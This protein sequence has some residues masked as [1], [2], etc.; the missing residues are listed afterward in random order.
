MLSIIS[1]LVKAGAYYT[2][3]QVTLLEWRL[4]DAGKKYFT[5]DENKEF[6]KKLK[7]GDMRVVDA[8]RKEKIKRITAMKNKLRRRRSRCILPFILCLGLT[9]C[10]NT[11]KGINEP[12]RDVN[13]LTASEKSYEVKEQN[14]KV[15][16][17]FG[18]VHFDDNWVLVHK[19]HLIEDNEIQDELIASQQSEDQLFNKLNTIKNIMFAAIGIASVLLIIVIVLL[20]RKK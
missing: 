11:P 5:D 9:G 8:I 3:G 10:I 13:S 18:S 4:S 20:R 15:K 19:D 16:G 2:K 7:K 17:D 6:Y 12:V 1:D 14:I